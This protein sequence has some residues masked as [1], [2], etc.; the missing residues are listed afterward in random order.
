MLKRY[1]SAV[2]VLCVCVLACVRACLLFIVRFVMIL[3]Y[4]NEALTI[5]DILQSNRLNRLA[6]QILYASSIKAE[7]VRSIS[8]LKMCAPISI[9]DKQ[10]TLNCC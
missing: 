4:F 6:F 7:F 9:A 5:N 8:I 1:Q 3:K 2:S 10:H